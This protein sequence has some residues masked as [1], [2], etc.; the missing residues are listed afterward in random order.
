[1]VRWKLGKGGGK[2]GLIYGRLGD[3]NG[4]S[5]DVESCN[6]MYLENVGYLIV[7]VFNGIRGFGNFGSWVVKEIS[8]FR[9]LR[10]VLIFLKGL[11][12]YL[13]GKKFL[14]F[15]KIVWV[16]SK[17]FYVVFYNSKFKKLG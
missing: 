12:V 17:F 16:N 13:R 6:L 15:L 4:R 14:G 3:V 5:F 8:V 7:Y 10:K 11:F 2:E 9:S 1:M